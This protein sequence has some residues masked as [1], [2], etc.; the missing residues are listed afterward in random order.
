MTNRTLVDCPR[1]RKLRKK[2]I[3][4]AK[5]SKEKEKKIVN[6]S[7]I[8]TKAENHFQSFALLVFSI[9]FFFCLFILV[10]VYNCVSPLSH[11][12]ISFVC[13][14]LQKNKN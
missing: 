4:T 5:N 8:K 9:F 11:P 2:K 3:T 7:L 6:Q 13:F 1:P 14:L 12:F 10:L